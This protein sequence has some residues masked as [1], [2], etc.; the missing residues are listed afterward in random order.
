MSFA[1]QVSPGAPSLCWG[2]KVAGGNCDIF[3]CLLQTG[4]HR[5]CVW[6]RGLGP[7]L[8]TG[9]ASQPGTLHLH[10]SDKHESKILYNRTHFPSQSFEKNTF[11]HNVASNT[12]RC[13]SFVISSVWEVVICFSDSL[14]Q[15]TLYL[16]QIL[17][18]FHA[19]KTSLI[20]EGWTKK[21]C[22]YPG[23]SNI[24]DVF[25]SFLS[26]FYKAHWRH[27][28]G[29]EVSN[30]MWMPKS[31]FSQQNI[32]IRWSLL[33]NVSVTNIDVTADWCVYQQSKL[34]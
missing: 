24:G 8:D 15:K 34:E 5:V 16:S 23:V 20:S 33:L 10:F 6:R 22:G 9:A 30:S 27:A 7:T 31:R 11:Q 14:Q 32:V 25:E 21:M 18:P 4:S 3:E 28:K 2:W 1:L 13:K 29:G 19:A 26:S 17:N 12:L